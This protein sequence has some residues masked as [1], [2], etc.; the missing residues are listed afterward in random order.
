MIRPKLLFVVLFTFCFIHLYGCSSLREGVRGFAG[1]STKVLEDNRENGL[2]IT[3]KHDYN[4]CYK[5]IRDVLALNKC[6]IYANDPKKDM[7]ALYVSEEDTTPVGVF[8]K[9]IDANSTLIEISSPSTYAKET[10][11]KV[12]FSAFDKEP[13][14]LTQ[15][16]G[17]LEVKKMLGH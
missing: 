3:F 13:L 11:A 1:V 10:I 15:K 17:Q 16:K 6:Y 12:V 14:V 7:I 8:L 2:K 4:S 9:A 5:K